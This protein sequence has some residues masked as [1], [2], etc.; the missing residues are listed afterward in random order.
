MKYRSYAILMMIFTAGLVSAQTLPPGSLDPEFNPG[1]GLEANPVL[2][3]TIRVRAME[4]GGALVGGDFIS[5]NGAQNGSL[6]YVNADGSLNSAFNANYPCNGIV[7][8]IELLDDGKILLG[9]TSSF[10]PGSGFSGGNLLVHSVAAQGDKILVGGE[11]ENFQGSQTRYLS[12]LNADGTADPSFE[13]PYNGAAY[14]FS[15]GRIH[16]IRVQADNKI[17]V[18]GPVGTFD[19]IFHT[20]QRLE[21]NGQPDEDFNSAVDALNGSVRDIQVLNDGKILIIGSFTQYGGT[22][23][24][25]ICRLNSDGSLDT[26]F[27]GAITQLNVNNVLTTRLERMTLQPDGKILVVGWFEEAGD[28]SYGSIVRLNADGSFDESWTTGSGLNYPGTDVS[29]TPD[30][31]IFVAGRFWGYNGQ[32]TG[33]LTRLLGEPLTL[34]GTNEEAQNQPRLYPNPGSGLFQIETDTEWRSVRVI[35][36]TGK[37]M[38]S[39][40]ANHSQPSFLPLSHLSEGIYF[41]EFQGNRE[42]FVKRLVIS[43]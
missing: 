33:A 39:T 14:N 5:F 24:G 21:E 12:R 18:A 28:E 32:S 9:S 20:F 22:T 23:V 34:T 41:V 29:V 10:S 11:F 6:L 43:K 26:G 38:W 35:D 3:S 25:R 16:T 13:H 8:D 27:N 40:A 17:L 1:E 42:R 30:G 37:L 15:N 2:F 19:E 36:L 31:N 7:R 4:D